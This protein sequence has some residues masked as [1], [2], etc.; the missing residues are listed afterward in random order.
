[1]KEL[2]LAV[3]L[4][5]AEEGG[6]WVDLPSLPGCFTQGEDIEEALKNAKEAMELH[7]EGMVEDD[8]LVPEEKKLGFTVTVQA[9]MPERK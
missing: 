7:L 1:M 4:H 2:Q 8:E 6:F 5:E 3:V 9:P